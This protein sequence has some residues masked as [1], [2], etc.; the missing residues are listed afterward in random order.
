MRPLED[1]GRDLALAIRMLRKTPAFTAVALITLGLAIGT[2]T[3]IFSLIDAVLLRPLNVPEANRLTLLRIQP[4]DFGYA[5]NYPLFKYVERH[6][7]VFSQVFAF[8]NRDLQ[9]HGRDGIE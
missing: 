3:A 2:N 5:F 6:A 9:V 7:E 1:F 8:S 4:D